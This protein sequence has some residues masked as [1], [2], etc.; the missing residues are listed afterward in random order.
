MTILELEGP[1]PFN[2]EAGKKEG[3]YEFKKREKQ[4]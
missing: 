4:V 3:L 1:R 2:T